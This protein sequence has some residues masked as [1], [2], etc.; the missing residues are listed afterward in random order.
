VRRPV[1]KAGVAGA[2]ASASAAVGVVTTASVQRRLARRRWKSVDESERLG[3]LRGEPLT[4]VSDDGVPLYVEIDEP[5]DADPSRP[6][7]VFVHGW[8]LNLDCWH[9]QR[10]AFR[11]THR[12]VL[13]DQ[14]CHGRSGSGEASGCTVEQLANDLARV[15]ETAAPEGPIVLIGHSMGGMTMMQYAK[16]HAEVM[17]ERVVGLSLLGASAGDLA[18]VL[19]GKPGEFLKD[20]SSTL[21]ALGAR[22]PR[23]VHAGRRL[24]SGPTFWF[25]RRFA[26]GGEVPPEYAAFTDA[27]I[28]SSDASVL[29][30]FWP[31]F[32]GL[33]EYASLAAFEGIPTLVIVGSEDALTPVRHAYRIAEDVPHARVVV[34]EG[35]GHM[36]MLESADEVTKLLDELVGAA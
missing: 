11:P 32:V 26:F 2:V 15:I 35:A 10:L 3:G 1:L 20:R 7:L 24:T 30:D 14:R 5:D 31:L 12:M 33:D 8:M 36:I 22:A 34:I 19:P 25:T 29:W 9:L 4:V 16:E 17:R 23:L 27:M 6:T 18:R 13:Y 28:S 21:F